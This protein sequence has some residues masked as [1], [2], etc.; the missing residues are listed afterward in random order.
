MKNN[1]I[2][3]HAAIFFGIM[4][5]IY[6]PACAYDNKTVH[7]KI[8]K[9][10]GSQQSLSNYIKG[11]LGYTDG[12]GKEFSGNEIIWWLQEGG[13][14]EDNGIR[15]LSHFHDPLRSWDQAG[16]WGNDS[17]L[18]WAQR[19][20]QSM[21][22][23]YSWVTARD[24][25]YQALTTGSEAEFAT[26]F[27]SLGQVMHLISDMAVPAHV[28]NDP[29]PFSDPYEDWTTVNQKVLPYENYYPVKLTSFSNPAPS[30]TAP[31]PISP[32][33]DKDIYD[34]SNPDEL[35]SLDAGLA[36]FTNA[37]FLSHDTFG[38]YPHPNFAD[39]GLLYEVKWH[40][41]PTIVA[42]DNNV[43]SPAYI[44]RLVGGQQKY[45]LAA[46]NYFAIETDDGL[47]SGF[48]KTLDDEVNRDYAGELIPRAIGY[49]TALLDY[50]LRGDIDLKP[51]SAGGYS[52]V[53]NTSEEMTG[54]FALYYDDTSGT[55]RKLPGAEWVS[56]IAANDR[57][58][59]G[60]I[61]I[62][63]DHAVPPKYYLVFEGKMGEEDGAVAGRVVSIKPFGLLAI[64]ISG[65]LYDV[66]GN[67]SGGAG[68]KMYIV[69]NV[70]QNTPLALPKTGGG[71]WSYPIS[72]AEYA[73][74]WHDDLLLAYGAGVTV[75]SI[76]PL[77][78][79]EPVKSTIFSSDAP[80]NLPP[81]TYGVF[82]AVDFN[83]PQSGEVGDGME[84]P[85]DYFHYPDGNCT[86]RRCTPY[87][88]TNVLA[89]A[90]TTDEPA[91]N[92]HGSID[93]WSRTIAD[94]MRSS[95]SRPRHISRD[96]G[97][98]TTYELYIENNGVVADTSSCNYAMSFRLPHGGSSYKG[99]VGWTGSYYDRASTYYVIS[100]SFGKECV[101]P[102]PF[103]GDAR[104]L[105]CQN[106]S[107]APVEL[108]GPEINYAA[109]FTLARNSTTTYTPSGPRRSHFEE[110]GSVEQEVAASGVLTTITGVDLP[111]SLSFSENGS[112]NN[113][114]GSR[115]SGYATDSLHVASAV[116][117]TDNLCALIIIQSIASG[118]AENTI[119]PPTAINNSG[120]QAAPTYSNQ[121]TS[122]Y[123]R[124]I[125][126][127][128][129]NADT[130]NP[131]ELPENTALA[132]ELRGAIALYVAANSPN[133]GNY[134]RIITNISKI[135]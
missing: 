76:S 57:I 43:D 33:W 17:A 63:D 47:V 77:F 113:Y 91:V 117:L 134:W 124:V 121:A 19:S 66:K 26:T 92:S 132:E 116:D 101:L 119:L 115:R 82:S 6:K 14:S 60:S 45:R 105:I 135:Q 70:G 125:C 104:A 80:P 97:P 130:Q 1:S 34:G 106:N 129:E 65:Y 112:V 120:T 118:T 3:H 36:E 102:Y 16:L 87:D 28:R 52:L 30:A 123:P 48:G 89:D 56:T 93:T 86:G 35:W 55:R 69:W 114:D 103:Q 68:P 29:H 88:V 8:N 94:S 18:V 59:V 64:E 78:A 10:A 128:V 110:T 2:L 44:W 40:D 62:P 27:R 38:E 9:A 7:M 5:V 53:N 83:R 133:A 61:A 74:D 95:D 37:N 22:G 99:R 71:L 42:E 111:I 20:D 41:R 31:L 81:A 51:G 100:A 50:F 72:A 75:A 46:A 79:T 12:I 11:N 23:T 122:Y 24:S 4:L 96:G 108:I 49:S 25:F 13:K 15:Y 126:A 21:F 67:P 90:S 107:E 84:S 127:A 85:V 73:G 32:L 98:G 131:W 54:T 39:P 58:P 109:T